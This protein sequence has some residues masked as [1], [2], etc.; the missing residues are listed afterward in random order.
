MLVLWYAPRKVLG[1]TNMRQMW[2]DKH[3]LLVICAQVFHSRGGK[4]ANRV[5]MEYLQHLQ[6][7]PPGTLRAPQ[8]QST[9]SEDSRLLPDQLSASVLPTPGWG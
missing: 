1:T 8:H 9:S 5:L 4:K 3:I 6:G 2:A 7:L